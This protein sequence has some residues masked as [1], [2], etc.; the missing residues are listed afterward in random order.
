M[1][2]SY[3]LVLGCFCSPCYSLH[4]TRSRLP[5]VVKTVVQVLEACLCPK[6]PPNRGFLLPQLKVYNL[7]NFANV[8]WPK[9][10]LHTAVNEHFLRVPLMWSVIGAID[11]P[12]KCD[13]GFSL[14]MTHDFFHVDGSAIFYVTRGTRVEIKVIIILWRLWRLKE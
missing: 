9:F 1:F 3:F 7:C 14:F 8:L 6:N 10:L 11:F 12:V 13:L 2:L 5:T 4:K